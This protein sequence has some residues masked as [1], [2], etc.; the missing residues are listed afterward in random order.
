MEKTR[1]ADYNSGSHEF[2]LRFELFRKY[3]KVIN[4]RFF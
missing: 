3:D 4:P 2:Y 1:L